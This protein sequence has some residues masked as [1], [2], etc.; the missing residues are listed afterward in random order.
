MDV[1]DK[2]FGLLHD[3]RLQALHRLCHASLD[4]VVLLVVLGDRLQYWPAVAWL[5]LSHSYL[6]LAAKHALHVMV[7]YTDISVWN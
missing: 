7:S 5:I 1:V 3:L 6:Q 4:L 2:H